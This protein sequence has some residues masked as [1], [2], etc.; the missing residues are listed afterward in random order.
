MRNKYGNKKCQYNGIVF[1]SKHEMERYKELLLLQRAGE[2]EDLKLQER[3][4]L[5]PAQYELCVERPA[6]RTDEKRKTPRK[7]GRI[8]CGFRIL[9]LEERRPR[10]RG[11][12]RHE[13]KG[14][15]HQAKADAV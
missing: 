3:F 15:H 6:Q 14:I 8:R 4:E 9:R 11:H 7:A 10:R 13:N 12:Q 1:D 5:I 2:I